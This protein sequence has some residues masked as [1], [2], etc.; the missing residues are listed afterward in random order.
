MAGSFSSSSNTSDKKVGTPVAA[1]PVVW[2]YWVSAGAGLPG[3][4]IVQLG[5]QV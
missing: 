5:D 4:N 2:R 3:V 1:L